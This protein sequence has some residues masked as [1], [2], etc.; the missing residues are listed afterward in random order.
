[1]LFAAGIG[2]VLALPACGKKAP[3]RLNDDRPVEPA[4][5]VRGHIRLGRVTLEF[6]VP[7]RRTFPEREDP[8]VLARILRQTTPSAE[9]V[10]VGAL[11]DTK[12]FAFDAPL[13]WS[14]TVLP[15]RSS[16]SYRVE[17]RDALRR[18]RALSGPLAVSWDQLPHAPS[19][20]DAVGR[21]NS[22]A[23]TWTMPTGAPAGSNYLIYRREKAQASFGEPLTDPVAGNGFVDVRIEP[24][25]DYCYEVRAVLVT[26]ALEVE[27]A[28]STQSCARAAAE[29]LPEPR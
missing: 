11:L 29:D 28:A 13:T 19:T 1:M 3:L 27:G 10:E 24:G 25:R 26:R 5:A 2:L 7:A 18:R 17:F 6:R 14:D 4:P 12:G 20:L 16:F 8:W 9:A 22:I 21:L 23:L 15:P